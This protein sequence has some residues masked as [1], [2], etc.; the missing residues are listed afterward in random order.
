[1]SVAS[2][3]TLLCYS[4]VF[5]VLSTRRVLTKLCHCCD[6]A[7]RSAPCRQSPGL[8]EQACAELAIA[9]ALYRTMQMTFWLSQAEVVLAYRE[10]RED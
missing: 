9:T 5:Y 3:L 6:I 1:M 10:G 7:V 2:C 8:R 4:I